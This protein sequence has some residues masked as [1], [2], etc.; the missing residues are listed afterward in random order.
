MM[1]SF[2]LYKQYWFSLGIQ[3]IKSNDG[4]FTDNFKYFSG[5]TIATKE[6]DYSDLYSVMPDG[7]LLANVIIGTSN[8]I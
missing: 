5:Y 4:I 8:I 7:S 3:K 6:T 2:S 1:M